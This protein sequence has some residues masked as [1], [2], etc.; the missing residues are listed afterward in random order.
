MAQSYHRESGGQWLL[1]EF[2]VFSYQYSV[3][4]LQ[5]GKK[6]Q[7]TEGIRVARPFRV[8][9]VLKDGCRGIARLGG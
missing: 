3:I 1:T 6:R 8:T 9:E 7:K 2:S 5:F 4:S